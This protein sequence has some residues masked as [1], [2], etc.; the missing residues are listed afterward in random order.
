ML[1]RD[2]AREDSIPS[3]FYPMGFLL[4]LHCFVED[5]L[6]LK[7]FPCPLA[8][9]ELKHRFPLAVGNTRRDE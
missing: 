5:A 4:G 6:S 2:G 1:G 8:P 7:Q 9:K 3:L